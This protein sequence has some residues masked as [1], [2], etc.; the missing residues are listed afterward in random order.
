MSKNVI[1]FDPANLPAHI[2][3]RAEEVANDLMD[4]ALS[5]FP[6]LSIKGKHFAVVRGDDRQVIMSPKDDE[7][8]ASYVDLVLIRANRNV[9]KVY[10]DAQYEDGFAGAPDCFSIDGLAPDLQAESPQADSCATC[11]HNQWG[12]RITESGK[13]AKACQDNRRVAVAA[14]SA[15]DDVML[16]RVPPASLKALAEYGRALASRKIDYRYAITRVKFA[17]DAAAPQLEFKPVGFLD[18]EQC[19]E[20]DRLYESDLVQQIIGKVGEAIDVQGAPVVAQ[21]GDDEDDDG[22][23]E[24]KPAKKA[25]KKKVAKKKPAKKPEPE[26]EPEEDDDDGG[27]DLDEETQA[28]LN[29]L[30]GED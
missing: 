18:E 17:Q 19:A 4:G 2:T 30:F 14:A 20:V 25:S 16:L 9:S 15:L 21:A 5:G 27:A 3:A 10:Y 6:I 29:E 22:V 24:P 28:L 12:S 13:K 11:P 23:D 1:P 8:P 7:T 26:P